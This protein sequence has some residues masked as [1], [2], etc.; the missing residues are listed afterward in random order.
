[1]QKPAR[2]REN[3]FFYGYVLVAASFSLQAIGSGTYNSFGG[4]F[5]VI[6]PLVAEFFGTCSHGAILGL[7]IFVSTLGGSIGPLLAGYIFDINGSYRIVF[8]SMPAVCI[9]G[10]IAT[11]LL[12]TPR[13]L[14][15][16]KY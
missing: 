12:H 6:S 9:V 3:R 13:E 1:M 16:V 10:L 2:G 15:S 4:F 8:L 5:A 7:V 14:S 11:P